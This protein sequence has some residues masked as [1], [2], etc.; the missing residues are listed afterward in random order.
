[1]KYYTQLNLSPGNCWQTA[2]ACLLEVEPD[3]LPPQVELES[4]D[5]RI[6]GGWGSYMN[7]LNGYLGKHHGLIYGTIYDFLFGA[8][9]P[10]ISDHVMCG[11]TVRTEA[12]KVSGAPHFHH[13]VVGIDGKMVWDVHPSRAGLIGV[14]EWGVLGGLQPCTVKD[15]Q[16]ARRDAVFFD[17]VFNQ[18][19]CPQCNLSKARELHA[20]FL[21]EKEGG[22]PV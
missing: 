17:L 6:L 2:V 19:L 18:C 14:R 22:L 13:C 7:V 4:F 11:P 20:K 15:R 1:M 12:L 5:S 10:V 21:A 3:L 16:N 8:V 9:K